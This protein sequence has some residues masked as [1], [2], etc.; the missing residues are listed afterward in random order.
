V[1]QLAR[2]EYLSAAAGGDV[3]RETEHQGFHRTSTHGEPSK[4]PTPS[5]VIVV[6]PAEWRG[7]WSSIG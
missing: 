4:K 6:A 2:T 7:R 3:Q 5:I 1:K